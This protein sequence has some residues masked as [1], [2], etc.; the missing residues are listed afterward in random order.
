[1]AYDFM[2]RRDTK[3][4]HHTSVESAHEMVK[5]YMAI[6]APPS[7]MNLGFAF[8]AKYFQV[9]DANFT[10]SAALGI[11]IVQAEN[12]VT[13]A[14]TLT[15][16]AITFETANM[17]P[18]STN[19]S[20]STDGT[21]GADKGTRCPSG[22][23]SQYGNCGTTSEYCGT[24]C[25]FAFGTGCTGP[26]IAGSWQTAL[27]KGTADKAAG[28][29]YYLDGSNKLFWTWD[30]TEFIAEKFDKIIRKYKLGG[31]M[32]WSLGEDSYDWSHIKKISEELAKGGYGASA[33]VGG[34]GVHG[35]R[36]RR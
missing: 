17:A 10:G 26:D 11:P 28:G 4:A 3:T 33:A 32:A 14:D 30:T 8:Y 19:I 34:N 27:V 23:C 22:C 5:N 21:C 25:Q 1:M 15:S 6:G 31:A 29:Q 13:G 18:I 35:H 2:N 20:T 9:P 12:P 7:K 36:H 16:G 24:G